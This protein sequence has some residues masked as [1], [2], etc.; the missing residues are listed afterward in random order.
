MAR[1]ADNLVGILQIIRRYLFFLAPL[2]ENYSVAQ[3][4]ITMIAFKG[5][6]NKSGNHCDNVPHAIK[7]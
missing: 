1:D 3:L 4:L 2:F 5:L 7:G 6:A